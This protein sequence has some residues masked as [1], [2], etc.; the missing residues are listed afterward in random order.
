MI[1]IWIDDEVKNPIII[2]DNKKMKLAKYDAKE[3]LEIVE[4]YID[5]R[6]GMW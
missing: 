6:Q 1:E 4:G 5:N 2:R 3:I